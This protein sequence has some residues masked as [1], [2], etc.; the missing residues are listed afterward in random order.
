VVDDHFAII[1]TDDDVRGEI[2]LGLAVHYD[3]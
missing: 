1:V 2:S 3:W